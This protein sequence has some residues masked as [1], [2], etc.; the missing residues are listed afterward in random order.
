[1]HYYVESEYFILDFLKL[2]DKLDKLS[3]E[4]EI[5]VRI[6][7]WQHIN[8]LK[9]KTGTIFKKIISIKNS[10]NIESFFRNINVKREANRFYRKYAKIRTENMII[11]SELLQND[12][13]SD[14]YDTIII[15]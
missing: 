4:N 3:N 8:D 12:K 7:L 11:L 13:K 9:R 10:P 1:M 6:K 2:L 14:I 15:N 5:Y